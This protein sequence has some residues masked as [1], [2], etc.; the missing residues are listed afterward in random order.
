MSL[1]PDVYHD[2]MWLNAFPPK[3]G[4]SPFI[5]PRS[6]ISGVPLDFKQHCQLAFGSYAQIHDEL[7]PTNSPNTRTVGEIC[8]GPIGLE[9]SIKAE[10]VSATDPVIPATFSVDDY[11]PLT[12]VFLEPPNT[13]QPDELFDNPQLANLQ[14]EPPQEILPMLPSDPD[15]LPLSDR[16]KIIVLG[17]RTPSAN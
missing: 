11:D 17:N 15:P 1:T 8:L 10:V 4:V 3:G 5:S 13:L 2:V 7:A 6:L 16:V 14:D 12:D 9:Q